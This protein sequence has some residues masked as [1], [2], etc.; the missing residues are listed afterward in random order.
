MIEIVIEVNFKDGKMF[1]FPEL[2][3]FR[4]IVDLPIAKRIIIKSLNS[5]E[6]EFFPPNRPYTYATI[7]KLIRSNKC[8]VIGS[9]GDKES[10]D[11]VHIV[12]ATYPTNRV[13]DVYSTAELADE[14]IKRRQ[15]PSL[16]RRIGYDVKKELE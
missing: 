6:T 7:V 10:K 12:L 15:I 4:Q 14:Y 3:M 8:V 13:V 11:T 1:N 16:Y 5:V 2:E 9:H